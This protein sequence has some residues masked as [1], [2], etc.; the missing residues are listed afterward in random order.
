M[1]LSPLVSLTLAPAGLLQWFDEAPVRYWAIAWSTWSVLLLFTFLRLGVDWHPAGRLWRC[2]PH[3]VLYPRTFALVAVVAMLAFRWPVLFAG[4]MRNPDETQL[5]AGAMTYWRD[6]VPWRSVD[7]HTSG[8]INAYFLWPALLFD[9]R[10][11]YIGL[12][13]AALFAHGAAALACYGL[14]RRFTSDGIA[15][16]GTLPLLDF[17]AFNSVWEFVQ[18]SSEQASF[19]LLALAAWLLADACTLTNDRE[20]TRHWRLIVAGLCLGCLPFAKAQAVGLGLTLGCFGL[21]AAWSVPVAPRGLRIR[22]A[23]ALAIGAFLPAGIFLV[24]VALYGQ[25]A[26]AYISY[27]ESNRVY[28]A[29]HVEDRLKLLRDFY[30]FFV[31]IDFVFKPFFLGSLGLAMAVTLIGSLVRP[32]S[33]KLLWGAWLLVAVGLWTVIYPGRIFWHYLHFLV[34]PLAWLSGLSLAAGFRLAEMKV[35]AR[36]SA[37]V[38]WGIV[39]AVVVLILVPQILTRVHDLPVVGTLAEG[40]RNSVHPVSRR[41]RELARPGDTLVVWGWAPQF[42]TESGLT[43][44][45]RD[46]QAEPEIA[47]GPMNLFYRN[48]MMW[49]IRKHPPALFVDAIADGGFIYTAH[50]LFGLQIFPELATFVAG[51]YHLVE[52]LNGYRIY[53]HNNRAP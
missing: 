40:Q 23:L 25:G 18:Y 22:R 3:W 44:G 52:D 11:D 50:S 32:L 8:P 53:V 26:Q 14:L 47:P 34:L 20:S 7:M 24:W 28:V 5:G 41:L 45:V 2:I 1:L 21:V 15:R 31:D 49:D 48:R 36:W 4:P 42:Y 10:I 51:H 29:G 13:L 16:L 37:H 19:C 39:T 17:V 38:R 46:A 43:Q 6:P 35:P 12:R 33:R 30:A 27:I 9:G